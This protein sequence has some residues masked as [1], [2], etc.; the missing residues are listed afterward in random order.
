MGEKMKALVITSLGE[1][2]EKKLGT[3]DLIEKDIPEPGPE[4]VRIRISYA[5]I[6]GSDVKYIK[7]GLGFLEEETRKSLPRQTGHEMSGVIDKVG[8][9][10]AK[11]GWK[12]GDRVTGN[13]MHFCNSCR[14]CRNGQESFCLHPHM[15]MDAMA[16]YICWHMS[17]LYK[18]PD[19][20]S[21]KDAV[22][23][24]PL[25][26][27]VHAVESAEV[28]FG[29]RLAI[30]GGGGIGLLCLI[31][32]KRK[33]CSHITMLEPME[34][35]RALALKLGADAAI[36]PMDADANEQALSYTEGFGYDAIIE[37]SGAPSAA[38][39]CI[40][41]L[42]VDSHVVYVAQYPDK[43]DL[44]INLLKNMWFRQIHV[45]GMFN[46]NDGFV[47][48]VRMLPKVKD[49][50]EQLIQSVHPLEEYNEA[51]ADMMSGKCA[52]VV[53]AVHPEE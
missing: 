7:G 23:T 49:E 4:E 51:F 2:A 28:K 36:N 15:H 44:P 53:F 1:P 40:N 20:V 26:V 45:H 27:A 48:T 41:L 30:S 11:L 32:A 50:L 18:V 5:S 12:E 3:M 25:S 47:K 24:E 17:Q 29:T 6:C 31:L 33:G 37:C 14:Y 16:E 22:L 42:D 19:E 13:F 34:E 39:N 43:F 8:A 46:S 21:L 9:E 38:V 10:A 52:K 35:K